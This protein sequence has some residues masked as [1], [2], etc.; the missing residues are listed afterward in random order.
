MSSQEPKKKNYSE[1]GFLLS[2]S[3][4][5]REIRKFHVV[6]NVKETAK[7]CT[8]KCDADAK[9]LVCLLNLQCSLMFSLHLN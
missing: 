9:L 4:F 7:K 1:V 6:V 5:K 8:K 2:D 3:N